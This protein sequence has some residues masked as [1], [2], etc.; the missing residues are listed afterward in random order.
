M[1]SARKVEGRGRVAF[2]EGR[3]LT[4]PA[5]GVRTLCLSSQGSLIDHSDLKAFAQNVLLLVSFSVGKHYELMSFPPLFSGGK[6]D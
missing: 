6:K 1:G 5:K 4:G 3:V 2:S